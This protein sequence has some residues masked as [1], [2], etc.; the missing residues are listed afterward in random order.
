MLPSR[1]FPSLQGDMRYLDQVTIQAKE[2]GTYW[3][4]LD[5]NQGYGSDLADNASTWETFQM[6]KLGAEMV[7]VLKD[8]E[9][10]AMKGVIVGLKNHHGR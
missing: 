4:A 9:V 5:S 10:V 6:Y 7:H 3:R 8:R 1:L 2:H